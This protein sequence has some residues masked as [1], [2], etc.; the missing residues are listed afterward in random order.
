MR[1]ICVAAAAAAVMAVCSVVPALAQSRVALV[2]GNVIG[3]SEE[4]TNPAVISSGAEGDA[5]DRNALYLVNNT[6]MSERPGAW[7]LRV[8]SRMLPRDTEIMAV[9]NLTVG[10]GLFSLSAPGQFHGNF[11]VLANALGD[12]ETLDF[13]L[14]ARTW[15]KGAGVAPPIVDGK[16]LAP[17]AEFALPL[18]TTPIAPRSSWTPG[19]FQSL[20]P[21]R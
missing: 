18:G 9:N 1:R 6:L 21:R 15:L 12:P 13:R 11:P 17:L 19:A 4:T 16:S 8:V 7:F 14:G 2:I 3:Q 5:W 10:V 20:D